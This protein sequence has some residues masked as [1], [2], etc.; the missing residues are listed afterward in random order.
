MGIKI[1]ILVV[2][3]AIMVGIGMYCRKHTTDVK[4]FVLGGCIRRICRTVW[5]EIRDRVYLDRSGKC[6]YRVAAGVGRIR[7]K[8]AYYDTAFGFGDHAGIFRIAF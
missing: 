2:Y 5:L 8:N 4:G 7:K 1:G 6:Y 3:F